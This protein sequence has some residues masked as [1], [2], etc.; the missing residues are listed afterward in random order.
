MVNKTESFGEA[1]RRYRTDQKLPLRKVAAYLDIDQA[2]LSKIERGKRKATRKQVLDLAGFFNVDKDNLLVSWLSDKI[3]HEL[4]E[5]NNS[6][7]VLQVAEEKIVY[8]VFRKTSRASIIRKIKSV[9]EEFPAIKKAWLFGSFARKED[10]PESDID[11]LIEVQNETEFTLFDISEIQEKL[12]L[13]INRRVDIVMLRAIRPQV[14]ERIKQDLKLVY[15]T[16]ERSK[17]GTD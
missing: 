7:K 12:K 17:Q 13:S 1:I 4:T 15:E 14:N 9:L 11:I 8:A 6:L 16:G 10:L 2:I 5:E 3:V